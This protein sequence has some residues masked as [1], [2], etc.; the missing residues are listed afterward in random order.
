MNFYLEPAI[1]SRDASQRIPCF[2]RC[3]LNTTKVPKIKN[4]GY[5]SLCQPFGWSTV[6]I[7]RDSFVNSMRPR[8][9][10]LGMKTM[11]K[12]IHR[13]TLLSYMGM[14]FRLGAVGSCYKKFSL[15]VRLTEHKQTTMND[16]VCSFLC[17]CPLG[18]TI[19]LNFNIFKVAS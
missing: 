4:R 7:L 10:P 11:R 6:A 5:K 15:A 14:G 2:D 9:I 18:H 17:S 8:A 13:F 3:Q 19:K 16:H 1:W 12:S